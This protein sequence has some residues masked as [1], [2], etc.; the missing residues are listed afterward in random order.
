MEDGGC[1]LLPM[2]AGRHVT[3]LRHCSFLFFP[4]TWPAY[5]IPPP[6]L[7]LVYFVKTIH[8]RQTN[9]SIVKGK[10][11]FQQTVRHTAAGKKKT[12]K[13]FRLNCKRQNRTTTTT[14]VC[15]TLPLDSLEWWKVGDE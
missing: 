2:G 5:L 8:H 11:I 7:P 10:K 13:S 4:P 9:S 14:R 12:Q 1:W 6:S 3:F 15:G